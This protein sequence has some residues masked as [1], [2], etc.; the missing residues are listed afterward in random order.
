MWT[1]VVGERQTSG[2]LLSSSTPEWGRLLR[3]ATNI[4]LDILQ[5]MDLQQHATVC[6]QIT[7]H[8]PGFV[9]S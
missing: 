9:F 6:L 2:T 4:P 7:F 5:D 1:G 8:A 3:F